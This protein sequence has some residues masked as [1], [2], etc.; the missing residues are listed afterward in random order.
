MP[1]KARKKLTF[2][3]DSLNSLMQ[4]IYVDQSNHK[5]KLSILYREWQSKAKSIEDINIIGMQILK[6]IDLEAKNIDQK[7][8][9]LKILK[10]VVKDKRV[11]VGSKKDIE[12]AEEESKKT[13]NSNTKAQI[14]E[15]LESSKNKQ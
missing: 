11:D 9:I 10:D 5:S 13:I 2:D 4:E 14:L 6:L 1:K 15:F 7:S 8:T 12:D 3:E